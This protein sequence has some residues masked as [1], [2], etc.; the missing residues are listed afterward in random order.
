MST[1]PNVRRRRSSVVEAHA[2]YEK[3]HRHRHT[4]K[5][6]EE[7]DHG[8]D[9]GDD[10]GDDHG[11]VKP[12]LVADDE[13]RPAT[14]TED[15]FSQFHRV[16]KTGVIYA[17]SRALRHGFHPDDPEW[18]N[19]GQGAPET[20]PLPGAPPRSMT[21]TIPNEE[22]E[23]APVTGVSTNKKVVWSLLALLQ[24]LLFTQTF[25]ISSCC[26]AI[27]P[28]IACQSGRLLQPLV[29]QRSHLA[30]CSRKY[31]HYSRRSRRSHQNHG[32]LGKY[33]SRLLYTRVYR[34]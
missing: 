9:E 23:Y 16:E 26:H 21:F 28:R 12:V 5:V 17:T 14:A 8:S 20:G 2:I 30:V 10:H 1:T 11:K 24:D 32:R 29:S 15:L 33:P 18:S 31:M 7:R 4:V 22:L 19:M 13:D 3:Y 34:L 27:D 25:A 6:I